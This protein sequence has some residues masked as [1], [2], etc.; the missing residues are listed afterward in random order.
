MAEQY[1]AR[2]PSAAHRA[3]E[4]TAVLRARPF[5][6]RTDSAVFS[7][8]EVDAG[9]RLLIDSLTI[10]PCES[11]LDLGCG[12]GPIGV[13]VAATVEGAH[14]VMTDVNRRA[15]ALARKNADANR[16]R[17][18]VREGA[19]YR[20]VEGLA[21]DHIASNPPIR[22]GKAVV[23]GIVEGAPAHLLEGGS[24]WLV[25]R[26]Q[27]GAPSL[28]RKMEEVFGNA[29]VVARG[30]GFRVLRSRHPARLK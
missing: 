16:V 17:A 12:Y 1:F 25:A 15:V 9:T 24:L 11:V 10:G 23:H 18:D 7:R 21:F 20:P 22:A 13:S 6:F 26:T 29:D 28:M 2:R 27:Q 14:V 19:L 30:G 8:R 4:F 3:L 5:T